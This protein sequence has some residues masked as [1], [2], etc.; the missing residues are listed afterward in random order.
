MVEIFAP[1]QYLTGIP[2]KNLSHQ[3]PVRALLKIRPMSIGV[4]DKRNIRFWNSL[5]KPLDSVLTQEAIGDFLEEVAFLQSPASDTDWSAMPLYVL[6]E[7]L[8]RA[9]RSFVVQDMADIAHLFDIH[10][11]PDSPEAEELRKLQT[12]FQEFSRYFENMLD[13]EEN[14]LFPRILRYEACLRDSRVHPEFHKGSLQSYLAMR[15]TQGSRNSFRALE[16]LAGDILR[17][18]DSHPSS[19]AAGELLELS[20][21]FRSKLNAHGELEARA[22]LPVAREMERSLYNLSIGGDAAVADNRRGPMDSGI[23]R[24]EDA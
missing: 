24:L 18:S 16:D 5:D 11:L 4:M 19:F 20:E 13:E 1:T 7:Y 23:L 21:R 22:L 10:A 8:T 17:H 6:V 2:M 15:L 14:Y 12:A 3:T 9:H